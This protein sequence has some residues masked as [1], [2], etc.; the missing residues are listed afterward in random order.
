MFSQ[1]VMGSLLF[2]FIA[3]IAVTV[4]AYF[5]YKWYS[6]P[7]PPPFP[8]SGAFLIKSASLY[9]GYP[10]PLIFKKRD[11]DYI[12]ALYD[13][14]MSETVVQLSEKELTTVLDNYTEKFNILGE[15]DVNKLIDV[16]RP[17][18]LE[19]QTKLLLNAESVEAA[20]L[21]SVP[22]AELLEKQIQFINLQLV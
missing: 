10:T 21:A 11:N 14:H 20:E 12:M 8:T 7:P 9:G 1:I 6:A 17:S 19:F 13:P 16:F 4:V 22:P 15:T 3:A 5:G 2:Y 18:I